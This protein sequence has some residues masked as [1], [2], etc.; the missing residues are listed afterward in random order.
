MS[1][2]PVVTRKPRTPTPASIAA[3]LA[4]EDVRHSYGSAESVRGVS[5]QIAPGEV[6]A[7]IGNSGCGKTTLLRLAAGLERLQQGVIQLEGETIADAAA[8]IEVPPEA[9]DIG[10]MFQDYAL[11]PHI[12]VMDNI[13]FGLRKADRGRQVWVRDRLAG[14]GLTRLA[15]AYPATLSGGEQQRV[16]LLRALAP[17]PRVMLLDEPFSAL[18]AARRIDMRE[19]TAR[20]IRESGASAMMVTHDGEEA[21]FMADRILVMNEGRIVQA[22]TPEDIYMQ[23]KSAFVASLFGH[24]NRFCERVENGQVATPLGHFPASG[25]AEGAVACVFIRPEGVL[26]LSREEAGADA[27]VAEVV[28]AHYLG[29]ASHVH[30]KQPGKGSGDGVTFHAQRSGRYLPR[31]G[32]STCYRIDPAHVFV[33]ATEAG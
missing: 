29:I 28:G 27:P 7:L 2:V 14:F 1:D 19:E 6:V 16:A 24:A 33:F 13:T 30:L 18:D 3:S 10:L 15:S 21:M 32:S 4:F 20:L 26:P 11:F 22:G 5:L 8:G 23:P 9:R 12:S 17:R 25:L 31:T